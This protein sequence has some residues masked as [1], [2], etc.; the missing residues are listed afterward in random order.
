DD[1]AQVASGAAFVVTR[2]GYNTLSELAAARVPTVVVPRAWPR[3]EQLLRATAFS[4]RGLVE[5]VD[6]VKNSDPDDLHRALIEAAGRLGAGVERPSFNLTGLHAL[7]L[8]VRDMLGAGYRSRWSGAERP[9]AA[10][11]M[12][13]P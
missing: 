9:A 4:T 11:A 1:I 6:P 10:I 12:G 5:M 3:M 2:G 13:R 8:E 7:T